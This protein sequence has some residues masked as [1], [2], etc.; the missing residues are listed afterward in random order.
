LPSF[1]PKQE[2]YSRGFLV[3]GDWRETAQHLV[4]EKKSTVQ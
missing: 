3:R 2:E 4:G 1:L